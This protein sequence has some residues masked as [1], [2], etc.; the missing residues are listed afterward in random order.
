MVVETYNEENHTIEVVFATEIEVERRSWDGTR[1]TEVLVCQKANVRLERAQA[2]INLVDSHSTYTVDTILGRVEKVWLKDSECRALIKLTKREDKAGIVEDIKSGIIGNISVGYR[3]HKTEVTE[4]QEKNTISVRV[5]DWEPTELSVLSVPADYTAGVRSADQQQQLNYFEI[6]N[7]RTMEEEVVQTTTGA[8]ATAETTATRS[9]NPVQNAPAPAPAPAPTT[10]V[11]NGATAER[12]RVAGILT[13]V[14]SVNIDD[15]DFVDDLIER[16][17]SIADANA[18]ILTRLAE[19]QPQVRGQRSATVGTER[20][21]ARAEGMAN[22]IEHRS[23]PSVELTDAGREYRGLTMVEI[24]R[25]SLE[26]AGVRTS[27]WSQREI[28]EAAL[29]QR[30]AGLHSTSDF[31]II[32]GNTVNRV[33][34]REYEVQQRTFSSWA[35]RGTAKDFR[36]MS[37][38][39]LGEVGDFKEVKEGGEYKYETLGE[40]KEAY[41]VVKYGQIIAI[42]WE[43]LVNDDLGAFSR[44]PRK[45]ASAAAR[46]QSDIVYEILT[47]SHKMADGNNL[48]HASHNNLLT[49]GAINVDNLGLMRLAVRQQKGLGGKDF[50][51]LTP[52]FLIVGP[53]QEQVAMQYLSANYVANVANNINV[54]AGSLQL[55]VDPRITGNAWYM[56]ADPSQIDTVEYAFLEGEPELFTETKNGFDVDGMQ[57]KA[58]MV[59]GA[60]AIDYRGLAKNPGA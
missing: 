31:P 54:W 35:S 45:I 19:N 48:F 20:Q 56:A 13:A 37:R 58:R 1:Y 12:Q 3:I 55:I 40:G 50:L 34:R 41:K 43:A 14:R 22:A 24:A 27:G 47:G 53:A 36:E 6:E 57:I 8:T 51:N 52:K 30:S 11:D 7:Q 29:S 18:E 33:L 23:N 21:Q 60:K 9:A 26:D 32:L 39:G 46:K 25:R 49:G 42:T 59:F 44:I 5:T 4:D 28:A 17:V 10:P 2:G 38:V 15:Q 16:G